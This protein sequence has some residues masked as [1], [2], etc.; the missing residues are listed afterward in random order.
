VG[1]GW[2][3]SQRR[4]ELCVLGAGYATTSTISLGTFSYFG[5][6]QVAVSPAALQDDGNVYTCQGTYAVQDGLIVSANIVQT[7]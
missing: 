2:L 6:D 1:A 7:G 5:P 4:Y 3:R